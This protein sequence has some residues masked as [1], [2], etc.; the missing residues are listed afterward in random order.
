M[1]AKK[2]EH[3]VPEQEQKP[4]WVCSVCGYVYDGDEPFEKTAG[5]LAVPAL[6]AAQIR[7]CAAMMARPGGGILPP[8]RFFHRRC[9]PLPDFLV[10]TVAFLQEGV[11]K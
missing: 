9:A 7:I 1:N 6:R 5:N 3:T 8:G 10:G 4:Q 2:V 11:V